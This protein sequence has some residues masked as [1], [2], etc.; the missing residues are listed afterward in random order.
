MRQHRFII[1]T[2]LTLGS[3]VITDKELVSQWRSVLRLS[4]GDPLILGDGKSQEAKAV[5]DGYGKDGATVTISRVCDA[6]LSDKPE[7]TLY[8]AILKKENFELVCQ[9]ATEIGIRK[10]V[11]VITARTVKLG[12]NFDRLEKIVKE[13]AEQ[14]G[15]IVVPDIGEMMEF[16]ETLSIRA[17]RKIIFDKSGDKFITDRSNKSLVILVGPEGGFEEK[18]IELAKE[19]GWEVK[20][21]GNST[22]RGETAAII[23]SY[24]ATT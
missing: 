14:S 7:V 24:V 19:A 15:Q 9:K 4:P 17:D 22:L 3:V 2:K 6:Q 16:G 8:C 13:A 10:I 11:P 21:L 18:E 20:S 12:L 23:A 5:L 1:D